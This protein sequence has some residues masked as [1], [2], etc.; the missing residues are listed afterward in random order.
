M[1]KFSVIDSIPG[2]GKSSYIIEQLKNNKKC[3]YLTPTC[4][5]V[6]RV[7][8]AANGLNQDEKITKEHKTQ[9]A[10]NNNEDAS[11]LKS[12]IHFVN[13]GYNLCATHALYFTL[14][15]EAKEAIKERGYKIFIDEGIESINHFNNILSKDYE[16]AIQGDLINYDAE[17]EKIIW[18]DEKYADEENAKRCF[19]DLQEELK[20]RD[21]FI[22]DPKKY[23]KKLSGL[24]VLSLEHFTIFEEV[25]F[26][27]YYFHCSVTA[28]YLKLYNIEYSKNAIRYID[29]KFQLVDYIEPKDEDR[30]YFKNRIN[31]V[32][33]KINA[34]GA[35]EKVKNGQ[36]YPLSYSWY[37][38]TKKE[39]KEGLETLRKNLHNF[40]RE[41]TNSTADNRI[42][43][44]FMGLE[45]NYNKEPIWKTKIGNKRYTKQHL[46]VNAKATNEY[47]NVT[48]VG[49]LINRFLNPTFI[50]ALKDYGLEI[51]QDLWALQEMLQFIFRSNIRVSDSDKIINIYCPSQRMRELLI[52]WLNN[53]I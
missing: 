15:Q 20:T 13:R 44:S 41:L 10:N 39:N 26:L 19:K 16:A 25:T 24:S 4:A 7:A 50:S 3:I 48:N 8:K 27:T 51:D 47:Q 11:K 52:K 34:I 21:I 9:M 18:I 33:G 49:Y 46:A 17:N 1:T 32:E 22:K 6:E 38:K 35:T 53:E 14:D 30:K 31:I 23:P 43:T 29:N 45:D 42:W 12:L 36:T 5:E 28:E 40:M 37:I 2:S